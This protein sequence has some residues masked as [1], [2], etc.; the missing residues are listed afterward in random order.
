VIWSIPDQELA[1]RIVKERLSQLRLT[2]VDINRAVTEL[3]MI[4]VQEM[5]RRNRA[6]AH[7]RE[8]RLAHDR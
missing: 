6:E 2:E 4:G 1:S 7:A 5:D 3:F 8:E